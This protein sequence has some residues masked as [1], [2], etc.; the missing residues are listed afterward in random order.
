MSDF[1]FH[2]HHPL[3][4]AGSS[5]RVQSIAS[6][7]CAVEASTISIVMTIVSTIFCTSGALVYICVIRT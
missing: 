1:N 7:T 3:T 5:I 2:T 6:V 4:T